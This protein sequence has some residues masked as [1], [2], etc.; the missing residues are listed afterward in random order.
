MWNPWRCFCPYCGAEL[1]AGPYS[2]AFTVASLPIGITVG[3]VAIVLEEMGRWDMAD[4]MLYFGIVF[5]VLLAGGLAAWP[6]TQFRL[7]Q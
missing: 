6:K 3:F 1:E 2:K 4:S 7:K 5:V